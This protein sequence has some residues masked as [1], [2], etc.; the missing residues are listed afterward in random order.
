[1]ARLAIETAALSVMGMSDP[2]DREPPLDPSE[3]ISL[4]TAH[5]LNGR[6]Q[7][8]SAAAAMLRSG[9]GDPERIAKATADILQRSNEIAMIVRGLASPR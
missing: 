9:L 8:I 2:I 4:A 7:G 6:L 5:A 1:M 3:H